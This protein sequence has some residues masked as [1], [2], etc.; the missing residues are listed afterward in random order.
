MTASA[1]YVTLRYHSRE[2]P[3]P[4]QIR[5]DLLRLHTALRR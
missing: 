2:K 5:A 1:G 3:E 4:G